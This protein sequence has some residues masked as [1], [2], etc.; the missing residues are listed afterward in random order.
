M[1][2]RRDKPPREVVL[3]RISFYEDVGATPSEISDETL[4]PL[5]EIKGE[6]EKLAAE[7]RIAHNGLFRQR[8]KK[9]IPH[10]TVWIA[11]AFAEAS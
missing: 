10:A 5:R 8:G 6:I 4:L 2:P 3:E 7:G 1:K 9:S 11:A